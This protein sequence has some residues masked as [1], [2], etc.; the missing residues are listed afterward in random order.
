[1]E[2]GKIISFLLVS[3]IVIGVPGPNVVQIVATTLASGKRR[4]LQ[5][6]V[7]TTL[8]MIIQLATAAL[9]T[10]MFLAAL[11]QGLI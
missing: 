1:M 7:G 8:A 5:T 3:A 9:G 11:S 2:L 4:G 10:A 6:I